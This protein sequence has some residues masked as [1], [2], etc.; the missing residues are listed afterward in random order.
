[1]L[2]PSQNAAAV[3]KG[4]HKMYAGPA[5]LKKVCIVSFGLQG[6]VMVLQDKV[7]PFARSAADATVVL[8]IIR[9]ADPADPS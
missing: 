9:G 2:T 3:A 7:G 1:M 6:F 4:M 5:A 8:D